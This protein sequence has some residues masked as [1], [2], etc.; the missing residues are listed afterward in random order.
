MKDLIL[1][2]KHVTGTSKQRSLPELISSL[3]TLLEIVPEGALPPLSESSSCSDVKKGYL[4]AVR[5]IHPDKLPANMVLE[6]RVLAEAVFVA[7]SE[8]YEVWKT[9]QDS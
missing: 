3:H 5:I 2:W 4:K 7:L 1:S 9:K 8:S 6:H